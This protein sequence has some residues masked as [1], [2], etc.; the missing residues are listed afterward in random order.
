MT[1]APEDDAADEFYEKLARDLYPAHRDQAIGE[2]TAERLRS[3][4]LRNPDLATNGNR[5]F[6]QAK[7]LY[8]LGHLGPALVCGVT[9]IEVFFKSGFLRPV[10]YGLVH[11]DILAEAVVKAALSQ[12]GY[13][14]YEP[15]LSKLYSELVGKDLGTFARKGSAKSILVEASEAQA[16]RNRVV[17]E[18]YDPTDE[19]ARQSI[20]S[21][22]IV[23]VNV[24]RPM[25]NALGLRLGAKKRVV[26]MTPNPPLKPTVA[27]KPATVA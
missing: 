4:Y 9:V 17:H 27:G 2:F 6:K 1:Y 20:G 8:R 3:Y 11:S 15:L 7:E 23:M 25:L 13:K 10:V 26:R 24:W 21:A 18:G 19:E 14:R 12:P 16:N 5:T 22:A